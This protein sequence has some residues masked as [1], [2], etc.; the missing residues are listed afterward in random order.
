M[1]CL[2]SQ[3]ILQRRLDGAAFVP[4]AELEQHLAACAVCRDRHAA[5]RPLLEALRVQP[6]PVL[7]PWLPWRIAAAALG[8]RQRRRLRLRRSLTVT[9]GLAAAIVVMLFAGY[10]NRPTSEDGK[11]D[12]GPFVQNPQSDV[13]KQDALQPQSEKPHEAQPPSLIALSERL[14]D[15]TL[16]EAKVLWTAANPVEGMPMGELPAV[17]DLDPA[18]QP[19]RQAKQEVNEGLQAVGRSAQRAFAYFS[20]ELPMIELPQGR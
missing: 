14:A 13:K 5:A 10:L 8:D 4:D 3:A 20:H 6:P 12:H 2:E 18:S 16:D 1:N 9:V 15:K 7:P 11:V 17:P 19:L